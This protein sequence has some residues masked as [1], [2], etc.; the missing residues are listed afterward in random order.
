MNSQY[1]FCSLA[2][3]QR[4]RTHAKMLAED[5]QKY[6]PETLFVLLTDKPKAFEPY[7]NVR[8]LFHRVRSVKGFHD[9][10]FVLEKALELFE[11]CIFVDA[12][13]RVL[14]PVP[15]AIHFQPGLVARYGCGILKHTASDKVRPS[16]ALIQA[17]AQALQLD[18]E[19]VSWFHECLFTC[20]RQQ[21]KEKDFFQM[22]QSI[23]YYFE[24]K[25][26][27]DGAGNVAGLAAAKS[28]FHLGFHRQDLFP[29]FKDNIQKEKIKQG[30][31]DPTL[32]AAE[33]QTHRE[34][35]Y[36]RRAFAQ[37]VTDK[38]TTTMGRSYRLLN[39]RLQSMQDEQFRA[40]SEFNS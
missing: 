28:G 20:S 36:P 19:E 10:R 26:V 17:V 25:G 5:L 22:W 1:C 34:I 38:V 27:Y 37:K 16:F 24:S 9:K 4:Y 15:Q 30:T 11:S 6:A 35:E 7:P 40:M 2:V 21:G 33:F 13:M 18:L 8:P 14:G 31:A 12:D 3:G 39:L 29:Y 23:A 32:M